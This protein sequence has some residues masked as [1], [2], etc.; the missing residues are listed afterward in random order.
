MPVRPTVGTHPSGRRPS[1]R[2]GKPSG[3][4]PRADEHDG[5]QRTGPHRLRVPPG[6]GVL[7]DRSTARS[8]CASRGTSADDLMLL[9]EDDLVAAAPPDLERDTRARDAAK[10]PRTGLRYG[11]GYARRAAGG[12]PAHLLGA[13]PPVARTPYGLPQ[14]RE[15]PVVTGNLR[16]LAVSAAEIGNR[17]H[18]H[19]AGEEAADAAPR[20]AASPGR[21]CSSRARRCGYGRSAARESV[22]ET[23]SGMRAR[24][25]I[26]PA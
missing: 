2:P 25:S 7:D 5:E 4:K 22:F 11:T 21:P 9:V 19:G 17:V 10:V 13:S 18:R 24:S 23:S 16:Q 26:W 15:A 6:A 20:G 8:I 14:R 3:S 1:G 12:R